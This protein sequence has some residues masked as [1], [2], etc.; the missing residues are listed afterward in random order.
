M[1]FKYPAT[2]EMSQSPAP[3][4]RDVTRGDASQA[5]EGGRAGTEQ[6]RG[7]ATSEGGRKNACA[8]REAGPGFTVT[9]NEAPG[10][11]LGSRCLRDEPVRPAQC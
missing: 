9:L 2:I 1:Q 8:G 7:G 10:R 3:L 4:A 5:S 6:G 11:C